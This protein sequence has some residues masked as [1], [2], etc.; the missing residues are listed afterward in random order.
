[1]SMGIIRRILGSEISTDVIEVL[2]QQHSQV[3]VLLKK[4]V[5]EK[6]S[7]DDFDLLADLLAAHAAIEE[8]I[9]YPA[10]MAKQ[11][12]DLLQ[13]SVE[14]HLSIKRLL[15][16]MIPLQIGDE[17]FKAKL[18]VLKEQL[19][20]HAHSEEEAKLFPEVRAMFDADQR[21]AIGNQAIEM[22]EA[23]MQSEPR[24]N[25][26]EEIKAAARLPTIH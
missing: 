17:A 8:Q 11:T 20:H 21:A 5:E 16:D 14:E 18:T 4:L 26:S 10:V 24:T 2:T 6:G 19:S 22:F 7:S 9:F 1:M 23:L 25:V 13:E 15:A 3:D 12:R